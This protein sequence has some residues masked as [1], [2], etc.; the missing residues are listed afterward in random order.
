MT[1]TI[2][3][4]ISTS[5]GA[6]LLRRGRADVVTPVASETV[7]NIENLLWEEKMLEWILKSNWYDREEFDK[8]RKILEKE[9]IFIGSVKVDSYKIFQIWGLDLD[10]LEKNIRLLS[11]F[12]IKKINFN[13]LIDLLRSDSEGLN[14]KIDLLKPMES[15]LPLREKVKFLLKGDMELKFLFEEIWIDIQTFFDNNGVR[16]LMIV[17]TEILK[18]YFFNW[19][20]NTFN[21][22]EKELHRYLGFLPSIVESSNPRSTLQGFIS[23]LYLL[24][25]M[26]IDNMED[27]MEFRFSIHANSLDVFDEVIKQAID[28]YETLEERKN[29][30]FARIH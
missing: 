3:A 4:E 19:L 2:K 24:N 12:S 30:V 22:D 9:G 13:D 21:C 1:R 11:I 23:K 16:L 7:S 14:Y 5:Q 17:G 28:N 25:R 27:L 18:E 15:S 20:R 10:R 26:W 8:K 29:Y 6:E